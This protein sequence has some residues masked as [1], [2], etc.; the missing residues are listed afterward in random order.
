[1]RT[2]IIIVGIIILIIGIALIAVGA[3]G[4]LRGLAIVNTFNQLHSGEYVSSE[5]MLNTSSIV[6]ITSP[7]STGGLIRASDLSLVNSS[8]L[9]SFAIQPNST[10]S[11]TN[12]F[13]RLIG[14]Y[15][16]VSFTSTQPSTQ[17]IITSASRGVIDY[18]ILTIVGI[19][20]L[21]AGIIV[22]IVGVFLKRP[23]TEGQ[24]S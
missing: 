5:V 3:L 10:S 7:S 19:S 16:Y 20:M 14:D 18:G 12:T 11:S 2:R 22:A 4:A 6:A 9:S 13:I 21:V 1:M 24:T 15:Y 23:K 17:I 8:N